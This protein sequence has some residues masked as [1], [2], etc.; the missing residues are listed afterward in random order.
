M[1][2]YDKQGYEDIVYRLNIIC[3][4]INNLNNNIDDMINALKNNVM[5]NDKYYKS[6]VLNDI[7]NNL[8]GVVNSIKENIIP[9]LNK[10]IYE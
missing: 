5:I 9:S 7:N 4:K 10:K 3:D 1:I 6:D 8:N 2:G